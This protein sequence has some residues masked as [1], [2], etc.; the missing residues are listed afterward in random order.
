MGVRVREEG[1]ERKWGI[2]KERKGRGEGGRRRER[3]GVVEK[4][5]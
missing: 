2:H 1:R 4:A 3:Q 5:K